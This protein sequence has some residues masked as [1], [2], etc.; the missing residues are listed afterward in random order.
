MNYGG[1]SFT[2]NKSNV[3]FVALFF[4]LLANT[5]LAFQDE[6]GQE[7]TLTPQEILPQNQ[8]EKAKQTVPPIFERWEVD[9]GSCDI[10]QYSK[11]LRFFNVDIGVV[12]LEGSGIV[13]LQDPGGA[14]RTIQSERRKERQTLYFSH[15]A[16]RKLRGWDESLA[17]Q[18]DIPL[19]GCMTAVF[20]PREFQ[21]LLFEKE[22]AHL[23]Q[24][25]QTLDEVRKIHFRV[26]P[27]AKGFQVQVVK[28]ELN[29]LSSERK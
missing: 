24:L 28:V 15:V 27:A 1:H 5:V 29:D 4:F 9:W 11:R 21:A 14:S 26:V 8:P 18:S 25:K 7:P 20:F 6:G 13:R 22:A 17:R 3:L 10:D 2:S 12:Q 19:E 16:R 23:K